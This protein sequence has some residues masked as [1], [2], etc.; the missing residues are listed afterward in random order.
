ME[1]ARAAPYIIVGLSSFMILSSYL[2]FAYDYISGGY[3]LSDIFSYSCAFLTRVWFNPLVEVLICL[4][5]SWSACFDFPS[6]TSTRYMHRV[7]F[8]IL[9]WKYFPSPIQSIWFPSLCGMCV[10]VGID[11]LSRF[12]AMIDCEGQWVVVRTSSGGEPII[13][14]QGTKVG[15]TF[16]LATR[17]W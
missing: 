17:A 8:G 3:L 6:S 12:G 5:G 1:E 11:L 15:S 2:L 16:C 7:F 4:L 14:G 13:Y 10:I 9:S